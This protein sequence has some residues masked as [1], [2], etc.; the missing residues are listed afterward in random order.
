MRLDKLT[1]QGFKSFAD[2]TEFLFEPGL[3]AF[4]GPNGCGKSNVVDAVKWVLGEQ[5]IKALRGTDM[6]DVIFNGAP[7]RRSSGYSEA[8]LTFSNTKGLL[9]TEYETIDIGRRLYRSGESEYFIN[10]QR[11]RLKDIRNLFMDTGVGM[12][13]YS[14]IEQGKVDIL[15][16]SNNQDRRAIFEEA[17]GISKYKSQKKTCLSKLERVNANLLR[18]GDIIDEVEKR[19]RSVKYQAAKARR[20]KRLDDQKREL[21]IALALHHYD[22][23]VAER[24]NVAKELFELKSEVGG[25]HAAIERMEAELSEHET[26][27]IEAD[28]RISRLEAE[29]VRISTQLQAAE[30]AV[31][32]NERR[33]AE[34]DDLEESTK[35][36]IAKDEAGLD[37]MR[38]E[39]ERATTDV[40]DLEEAIESGKAEVERGRAA[41]AAADAELR[42]IRSGI[43]DKRSQAVDLASERAKHNNELSAIAAQRE[44]LVRQDGRLAERA[45]AHQE[46]L[47]DA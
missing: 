11:C 26:A 40:A 47:A 27:V 17:A 1:V 37:L 28:Q 29:D 20:W 23:L 7:T 18:L 45:A 15:L 22:E 34:L 39:L 30:E 32:M 16:T 21:A 36:E 42:G 9:P 10:K 13:A 5:S 14:I 24:E 38:S 19:M 43:E 31:K 6:Q 3:T 33:L 44:Q 2:K 46:Q 12:D 41:I 4:V 35:A 8:T 25:L